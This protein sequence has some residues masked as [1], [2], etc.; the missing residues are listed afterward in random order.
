MATAYHPTFRAPRSRGRDVLRR[1]RSLAAGPR[2]F[3]PP[4]HRAGPARRADVRRRRARSARRPTCSR[5]APR[6]GGAA[7]RS[8]QR[9]NKAAAVRLPALADALRGRAAATACCG[10]W[11][12][13]LDAAAPAEAAAA[14]TRRSGPSRSRS[15]RPPDDAPT[16]RERYVSLVDETRRRGRGPARARRRWRRSRP[17]RLARAALR[18]AYDRQQRRSSASVIPKWRAA[19]RLRRARGLGDH[20]EVFQFDAITLLTSSLGALVIR[21][22]HA[23]RSDARRGLVGTVCETTCTGAGQAALRG[24]GAPARARLVRLGR[25]VSSTA[26]RAYLAFGAAAPRRRPRRTR[27]RHGDTSRIKQAA[28]H[29]APRSAPS[30]VPHAAA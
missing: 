23:H 12:P 20:D 22:L 14:P 16:S 18:A 3:A 10:S 7:R 6:S 4:P 9:T 29:H 21:G 27:P 13:R 19:P 24:R 2:A 15:S 30:H 26:R 5:R 8:P 17:V 1:A 11:E 25:R 28:R